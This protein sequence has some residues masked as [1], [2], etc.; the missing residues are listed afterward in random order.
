M[1]ITDESPVGKTIFCFDLD[2]TVTRRELLPCIASEI[3]LVEE[4]DTLTQVTLQ[5]LIPFEKSFRL[6]CAILRQVPI[7]RVN[8]VVNAIEL[9]Q[10]IEAF[11]RARAE[12]CVIVTGNLDVWIRPIVERLGCR[13]FCSEGDAEGD[14]LMSVR[15]VLRKSDAI[16]RLRAEHP[17]ARIV[18]IGESVNDL[19]MFEEADVGVAYGGVHAPVA[20]IIGAA[21]YVTFNG[22]ALCRLLSTL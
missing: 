14:Q 11:I 13:C 3:G 9:D 18:A 10:N 16:H 12:N 1:R 15:R 4:L 20:S 19:P 17:N 21:H 7:S 2:G 22:V 5:G 8:A 6:R